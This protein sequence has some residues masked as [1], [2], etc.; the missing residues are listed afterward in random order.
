MDWI[1]PSLPCICPGILRDVGDLMESS[2][3]STESSLDEIRRT[4]GTIMMDDWT[5]Y[6]SEAFRTDADDV[7]RRVAGLADSLSRTRRIVLAATRR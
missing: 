4:R 6:A 5:G 2:I 1:S 7:M 3:R